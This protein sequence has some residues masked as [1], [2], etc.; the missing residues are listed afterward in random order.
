MV[1]DLNV[2]DGNKKWE[3]KTQPYETVNDVYMNEQGGLGW[4][5][6]SVYESGGWVY[7]IF[8]RQRTD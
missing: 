3:Y 5:L 1:F 8:K 2:S 4:E 7:H 6:V